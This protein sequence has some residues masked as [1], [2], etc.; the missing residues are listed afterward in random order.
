MFLDGS[1]IL[2]NDYWEEYY[3]YLPAYDYEPTESVKDPTP[4]SAERTKG[5]KYFLFRGV[6][7]QAIECQTAR[8]ISNQYSRTHVDLYMKAQ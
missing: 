1:T 2:V 8:V 5:V 7:P 6:V 4:R 3:T